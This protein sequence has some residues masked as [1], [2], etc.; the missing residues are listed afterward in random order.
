MTLDE[1]LEKHPAP[2]TWDIDNGTIDAS[3]VDVLVSKLELK[4]VDFVNRIHEMRGEMERRDEQWTRDYKTIAEESAFKGLKLVELDA[5]NAALKADV[6]ELEAKVT[7]AKTQLPTDIDWIMSENQRLRAKHTRE[8]R[9]FEASCAA[10]TGYRAAEFMNHEAAEW[11]V[12][13][14]DALLDALDKPKAPAEPP[15][16]E[17]WRIEEPFKPAGYGNVTVRSSFGAFFSM[18]HVT[19]LFAERIVAALNGGE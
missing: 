11:A 1:L 5:E 6:A 19:R 16:A 17:V 13:D 15:P 14:A 10:L 9:R 8:Q 4:L 7:Y 12:G 18:T 3:G 2:W